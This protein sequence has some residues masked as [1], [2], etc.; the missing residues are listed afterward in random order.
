MIFYKREMKVILGKRQKEFS[1]LHT[2]TQ[3]KKYM[4]GLIYINLKVEGII[5]DK[6]NILI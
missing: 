2:H 6:N 4:I 3:K 1:Y 5:R